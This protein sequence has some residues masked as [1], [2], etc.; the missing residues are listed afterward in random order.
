MDSRLV[1]VIIPTYNREA[2]LRHA[3]DSALGQTH[4]DIEV[5]VVD[6]GSTDGTHAYVTELERAHPVRLIRHE[7]CA[8]LSVLRNVGA[9]RSLGAYVALLDSDDLWLPAKIE[10]QLAALTRN[11]A[12]G[13]SYC[14]YTFMDENERDLAWQG[15]EPW[16][17]CGGWILEDLIRVRAQVAISTV[18]VRRDVFDGIGGFDERLTWLE[19]YDLAVRLA[20]KSPASAQAEPLVRRR[21][22]DRNP[23]WLLD[24]LRCANLVYGELEQRVGSDAL[25]RACRDTRARVSLD[26]VA[27]CRR[28]GRSAEAR[29]ALWQSFA[30]AGQRPRWWAELARTAV[31]SLQPGS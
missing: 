5:L 16:A 13:W 17:A 1:S 8:N 25:R 14:N 22:R 10:R 24:V 4:R 26:L 9:R 11:P 27:R 31:R 2:W 12:C 20:E 23:T 30:Y 3:I 28:S 29:R 19:D 15:R 6:D 21:E 7:H 18:L